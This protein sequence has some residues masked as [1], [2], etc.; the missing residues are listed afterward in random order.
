MKNSRRAFLG[1][2]AAGGAGAVL[3][4]S[5]AGAPQGAPAWTDVRAAGARGDG[6]ADDTAAIRRAAAALPAEGGTLY[7]PPGTYLVSGV[8]AYRSGQEWRFAPGARLRLADR[9]VDRLRNNTLG[10]TLVGML[11]PAS[12]GVRG[13]RFRGLV[14][15]GNKAGNPTRDA[16]DGLDL[17]DVQDVLVEDAHVADCARDGIV[18]GG[19]PGSTSRNVHLLGVRAERCGLPGVNGGNGIAVVKGEAVVISGFRAAGNRL[20]GVNCETNPGAPANAVTRVLIADG[21]ATDTAAGPGISVVPS[22]RAA[23]GSIS[24]ILVA[25]VHARGNRTRGFQLLGQ[26]EG[27]THGLRVVGCEASENGEEGFYTQDNA[28]TLISACAARGNSRSRPG[29]FSAFRVHG[30]GNVVDHCVAE[31]PRGAAAHA[32]GF[33]EA[34]GSSGNVFVHVRAAGTSGPGVRMISRSS[35]R[36]GT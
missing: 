25:R 32:A 14:I 11:Q 3:A 35:V 13:V 21:T 19:G 9:S 17:F 4:G 28:G 36:V 20:F 23:A 33:D 16:G 27:G 29:A 1:A 31:T 34:P 26:P 2:L 6:R 15:D 30:S 24:E 18:V 7:F 12:R 22:L 10:Y 8:L 5:R